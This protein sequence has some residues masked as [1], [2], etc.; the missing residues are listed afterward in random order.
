MLLSSGRSGEQKMTLSEFIVNV[1]ELQL[2]YAELMKGEEYV[3][4]ML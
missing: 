3:V 4:V 1:C 2:V